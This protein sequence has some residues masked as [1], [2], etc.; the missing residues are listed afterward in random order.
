MSSWV[1]DDLQHIR[2][3]SELSQK[4]ALA[5]KLYY[6]Q[7]VFNQLWTPL[8]F[9]LGQ[10]GIAFADLISLTV[11]LGVSL[12]VLPDVDEA[13]ALLTVPYVAWSAYATYLSGSLW[14]LNGGKDWVKSL[15]GGSQPSLP[16]A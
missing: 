5:L 8:S 13:A 16:K 10:L 2:S 7:L 15:F 11:T 14:Y 6:G 3:G 4:A 12:T 9:G 1:S